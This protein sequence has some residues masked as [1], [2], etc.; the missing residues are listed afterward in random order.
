ML[1]LA[2]HCWKGL[3]FHWL[4]VLSEVAGPLCLCFSICHPKRDLTSLCGFN[5]I[6]TSPNRLSPSRKKKKNYHQENV[7]CF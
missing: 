7:Y 1:L 6:P 5:Q 2:L 4:C 3:V